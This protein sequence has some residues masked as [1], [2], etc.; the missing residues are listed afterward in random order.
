MRSVAIQNQPMFVSTPI[1]VQIR[2]CLFHL[3]TPIN[4]D[5][6]VSTPINTD[7]SFTQKMCN[8]TQPSNHPQ[9][10]SKKLGYQ[11][12]SWETKPLRKCCMV[13]PPKTCCNGTA[14]LHLRWRPAAH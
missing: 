12:P 8:V 13:Y 14:V 5:V 2:K 4:T 9:G 11:H 10:D 3:S 1:W 7:A 6:L